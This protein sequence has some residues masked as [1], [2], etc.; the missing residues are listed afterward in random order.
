[1]EILHDGDLHHTGYASP[2]DHRMIR[3]E[4]VS[5][6]QYSAKEK[7]IDISRVLEEYLTNRYDSNI[8]GQLLVLYREIDNVFAEADPNHE[9]S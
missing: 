5:I 8:N 7:L 6:V 2:T 1:M 4:D 9:E 3:L